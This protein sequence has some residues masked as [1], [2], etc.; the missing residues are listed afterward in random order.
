MGWQVP[1]EP[2]PLLSGSH[3]KGLC[4]DPLAYIQ[5]FNG[6]AL[7]E[8]A[9]RKARRLQFLAFVPAHYSRRLKVLDLWPYVLIFIALAAALLKMGLIK[10]WG[11]IID[12][13]LLAAW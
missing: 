5:V 12:S 2:E 11:L 3:D 6:W 13:S 9:I 1:L 7:A 4:I 10:G 8:W